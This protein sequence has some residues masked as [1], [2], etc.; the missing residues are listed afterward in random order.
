MRITIRVEHNGKFIS[1]PISI[2]QLR[3]VYDALY[4]PDENWHRNLK[5]NKCD[6]QLYDFHR[7]LEWLVHDVVDEGVSYHFRQPRHHLEI[8]GKRGKLVKIERDFVR[9]KGKSYIVKRPRWR[10]SNRWASSEK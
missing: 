2:R 9:A 10:K 1:V 3:D 6:K 8:K 5:L 7:K 4:M